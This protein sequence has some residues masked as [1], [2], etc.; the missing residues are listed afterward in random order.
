MTAGQDRKWRRFERVVAAIHHAETEGAQVAWNDFINGRQF[1]VTIRF[2]YG[3]HKYLSVIECKDER[4]KIS[5]DEV[6]AFVTKAA[7]VLANKAIMVS[8][9]GF[10]SGCR[11]VARRHAVTLLTLKEVED[12]PPELLSEQLIQAVNIYDIRVEAPEG[13][14]VRLPEDKGQ[15]PYLLRKGV[16]SDG[17]TSESLMTVVNAGIQHRIGLLSDEETTLTCN[18]PAGSTIE[19]PDRDEL[20]SV[21]SLSFRCRWVSARTATHPFLD[22]PGVYQSYQLKDEIEGTTKTIPKGRV[23]HGFDTVIEPGKFYFCP[24]LVFSYFCKAV[25]G[26]DV[27]WIL[28]ESY[29]HGTL[30]QAE[31]GQKR[32][33]SKYY[34]EITDPEEIKRLVRMLDRLGKG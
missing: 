24:S 23:P 1:D 9:S 20:L 8:S 16:A 17:K 30:I 29:Q 22:I 7:D 25:E 13:S 3:L 18:F 32:E 6:E 26:D 14:E 12:L 27:T 5:I 28:L 34:V 2:E 31:I 10:Q 33:C 15:L 11:D 21:K 4:R 19:L